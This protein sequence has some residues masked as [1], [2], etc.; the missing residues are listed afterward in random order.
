MI[1]TL[2]VSY[3]MCFAYIFLFCSFLGLPSFVV[4]L[5]IGNYTETGECNTFEMR[6][7]A[8]NFT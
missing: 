6:F 8:Q 7:I 5:L 3:F 4:A 1:I 2:F